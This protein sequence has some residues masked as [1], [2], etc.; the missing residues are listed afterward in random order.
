VYDSVLL[1]VSVALVEETREIVQ[2]AMETLPEGF[3]VP[4]KVDIHTG[5]AW[6]DC[7]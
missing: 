7:K 1:E 6:A 5:R 3:T 2:Y 4:L